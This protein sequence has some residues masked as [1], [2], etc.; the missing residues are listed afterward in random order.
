MKKTY[1]QRVEAVKRTIPGWKSDFEGTPQLPDEPFGEYLDARVERNSEK[2]YLYFEDQTVSYRQLRDRVNRIAN[3]LLD[4]GIK[5]GAMVAVMTQNCPEHLYCMYALEAI[6]AV[7]VPI[8]VALVGEGLAYLLN[9]SDSE[10]IIVEHQLLNAVQSVESNL[11]HIKRTI[12]LTPPGEEKM[13]LPTGC[14][15]FDDLYQSSNKT[16]YVRVQPGEMLRIQYTSGTTGLPKG[17][18]RR[19]PVPAVDRDEAQIPYLHHCWD[20]TYVVLPLFHVL[21]QAFARRA[22]DM[23]STVGMIRRFSARRFWPEVRRFGCTHF[24]CAGSIAHI[25]LKQPPQPD[26]K[27]HPMRVGEGYA[28]LAAIREEFKE[29]FGVDLVERYATS[30]GGG[31]LRSL[32]GEKAGSLGRVQDIGRLVRLVDENDNDCPPH[33]VGEII[34]KPREADATVEYYKMPEVSTNKVRGGWFRTGDYGYQ[35]EEGWMFFS[36]R[37]RQFI[38]RMGENISSFEIESVIDKHPDVLES[39][40]VGV[41]SEFGAGDQEVKICLVLKPGK[42]LKPEELI[43]FC[44]GRMAYYLIPRYVDI[45]KSLPKTGTERV[46]KYMLVDEGVTDKMWDSEAAGYKLKK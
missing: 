45:R 33:A 11:D 14:I 26:D 27:D 2:V 42:K 16:P 19:F 37:E 25:L 29:R 20:T 24:C 36:D 44:E 30:D 12:A 46:Q 13:S 22:L 21:G 43:A 9:H 35:D 5:K 41:H 8:N 34:S 32:P 7:Y 40:A 15:P 10:T 38:R 3:G 1:K 23:E 17:T 18:V 28:P 6:G 4:L 31:G 39:A